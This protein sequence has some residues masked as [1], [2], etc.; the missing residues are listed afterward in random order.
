MKMVPVRGF[1]ALKNGRAGLFVIHSVVVSWLRH[2]FTLC[3]R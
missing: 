2:K 3:S 1:E